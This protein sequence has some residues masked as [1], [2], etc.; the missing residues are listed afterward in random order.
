MT[1]KVWDERLVQWAT[2]LIRTRS[3]RLVASLLAHSGDSQWW[4]IGGAAMW[5]WGKGGWDQVG[6]RIVI[7]TLIGALVSGLLKRVIRRP[8]P[9]GEAGLLYLEFDR[10]SFPSGHATRIGGLVIVL[11]ILVPY[12]GMIGLTLWGLAVGLARIALGVHYASDI[13]VG[14]LL[15]LLLGVAL[16]ILCF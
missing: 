5:R 1:L 2:G 13:M 12:W 14:Y 4:L 16:L 8:R 6:N 10:H 3:A 7:V 15:G 11:G 9:H